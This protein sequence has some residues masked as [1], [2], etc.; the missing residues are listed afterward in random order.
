VGFGLFR[1]PL[2]VAR[3]LSTDQESPDSSEESLIVQ[4]IEERFLDSSE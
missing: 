1:P 4:R 3:L 2:I